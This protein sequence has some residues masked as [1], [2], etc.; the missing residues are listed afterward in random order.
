MA[1][2]DYDTFIINI[3]KQ[4][5]A[6]VRADSA[7]IRILQGD[8]LVEIATTQPRAGHPRIVREVSEASNR[9]LAGWVAQHKIF[10][11]VGDINSARGAI[12]AEA[13]GAGYMADRET[14]SLIVAPIMSGDRVLGVL[15]LRSRRTEN[16]SQKDVELVEIYSRTVAA[17]IEAKQE[18]LMV[19]TAPYVFVLMPF[20]EEFRDVYELGIKAVCQGLR[21]RCERVDEMDFNDSILS[22]IYK[23][24]QAADVVVADMT[25]RNPNVFYEVGYAHALQKEVIL[26]TQ[27]AS[28]IPFDLKV[29]NHIIYE[30]KITQLQALLRRRLTSSRKASNP[31]AAPDVNRASRS[32][33]R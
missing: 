9:S 11:T 7:D 4:A 25:D 20:D 6:L 30:G 23:S 12:P 1:D 15:G 19:T 29:H 28:D 13:E 22:Q 3:L 26:L 24:I 32:R 10:L 2:S 31:S 17:A 14:G 21:Y 16:F 8:D 18:L 5:C 33:R 27:R